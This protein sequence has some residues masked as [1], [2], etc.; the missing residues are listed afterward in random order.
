MQR[1]WYRRCG[2]DFIHGTMALS[3]EEKGAYSLCLDLIYD[4][5]GP[6]PDDERWIAG[7]CGVSARR[8]RG[9][10]SRL[11][12][13]GKLTA[14]DGFLTNARAQLEIVSAE[15]SSRKL[16]ESGSKG[17]RKR[18]ENAFDYNVISD[19]AEAS[20]K[21][22]REEKRREEEKEKEVT[23]PRGARPYAFEGKIIRLL[24]DQM[25]RWQEAYPLLDLPAVL[26][27]RDDWLD[28][29]ADDK[30]RRKWFIPTSNYLAGLQQKATS[31]ERQAREAQYERPIV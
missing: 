26:Q 9:I 10:R 22:I 31:A 11:I 7:V 3:L 20:L 14:S 17:G 27:S 6:I 4:R 28:Q 13:A 24:P 23:A 1:R 30:L 19:L 21:H 29:E 2:A 18:A 25:R 16:A 5:G 8:W 15:I 12:E